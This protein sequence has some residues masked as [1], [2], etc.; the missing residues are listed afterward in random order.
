LKRTRWL[1]SLAAAGVALVSLSCSARQTGPREIAKTSEEN[2]SSVSDSVVVQPATAEQVLARVRAPGARVVLVN[3]WATWC[4]PCR[5]EFPDLVRLERAYRDRGLRL[6]FVSGDFD[7]ELP[8]VKQFLAEQGVHRPTL[9][10]TGDDMRF[11]DAMDRRWSGALPATWIYDGSGR[12]RDFWEGKASYD[13]F[14]QKILQVLNEKNKLE[15][16]EARS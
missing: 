5:E 4:P 9:L 6:I 13:K 8:Q 15:P 1:L 3:M 16:K 12:V 11:I 2:P 14:E 10:K 7:S